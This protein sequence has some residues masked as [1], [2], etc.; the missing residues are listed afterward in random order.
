ML[1]G[2]CVSGTINICFYVLR[3]CLSCGWRDTVTV[4]LCGL[5]SDDVVFS[6]CLAGRIVCELYSDECPKTCENFRALCT[7]EGWLVSAP[8]CHNCLYTRRDLF[9]ALLVVFLNTGTDTLT[10]LLL[11]RLVLLL[12]GQ[13]LL[14]V[15]LVLLL[16][17]QVMLLVGLVLLLVGLVTDGGGRDINKDFI[18]VQSLSVTLCT[19]GGCVLEFGVCCFVIAL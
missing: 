4:T 13:V 18:N 5:P 8:S 9:S 3:V 12:V 17:G 7:G 15:G 10:E 14:L 19:I 16:V 11:V 2:L 1:D 6:L